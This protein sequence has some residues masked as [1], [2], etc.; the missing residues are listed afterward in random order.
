M[1]TP[2]VDRLA[3]DVAA[4]VGRRM[5]A[6]RHAVYEAIRARAD[7]ECAAPP[8]RSVP[9]RQRVETPYLNEPWYC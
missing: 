4:I 6:D 9:N 1:T 7:G 8:R 2:A 3:D 5:T